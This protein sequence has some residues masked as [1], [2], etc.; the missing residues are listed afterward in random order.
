MT[1]KQPQEVTTLVTPDLEER[2]GVWV[3]GQTSF[4]VS[5]S[6]IRKWAISSYLPEEPPP[7][8]WD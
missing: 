3:E 8:V 4:P 7:L 2:K 1:T 5:W 6:D